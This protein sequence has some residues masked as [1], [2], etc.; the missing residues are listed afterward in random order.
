MYLYIYIYY[1]YT[2]ICIYIY[3]YI[4]LSLY[5]NI[6]LLY[7]YI[8]IYIYIYTVNTSFCCIFGGFRSNYKESAMIQEVEELEAQVA[9]FGERQ[10]R[11]CRPSAKCEAHVVEAQM[12]ARWI[13]WMYQLG[14]EKVGALLIEW[15]MNG[16]LMMVPGSTWWN[17]KVGH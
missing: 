4:H 17:T 9:L 13:R 15:N 16:I 1:T 12:E 14:P 8:Y 6:Y 7:I 5:I 3:I 10:V 2:H 11:E